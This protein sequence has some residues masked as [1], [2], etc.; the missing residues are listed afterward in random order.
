MLRKIEEQS[1]YPFKF[2]ISYV[3]MYMWS[4]VILCILNVSNYFLVNLFPKHNLSPHLEHSLISFI[5]TYSRFFTLSCT[6][7]YCTFVAHG[8]HEIIN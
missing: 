6:N 5:F 3:I 2:K 4:Y 7:A 8:T 1:Y